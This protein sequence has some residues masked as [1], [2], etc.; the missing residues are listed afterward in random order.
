M[1]RNAPEAELQDGKDGKKYTSGFVPR[2]QGPEAYSRSH[3]KQEIP[4][5]PCGERPSP[6]NNYVLPS[7]ELPA[8]T[9][10]YYFSSPAYCKSDAV[11]EL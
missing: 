11:L 2:V 1:E 3:T 10:Q 8:M 6:L 4:R 7:L 5:V 9:L